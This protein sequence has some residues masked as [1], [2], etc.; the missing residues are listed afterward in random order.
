MKP[1]ND[2]DKKTLLTDR[3]FPIPDRALKHPEQQRIKT[4]LDSHRGQFYVGVI[5]AGRRSFKTERFLK[6]R[7]VAKSI[8][9]PNERNFLGAP[10]RPQAKLI[11]WDDV[12]AL[13]PDYLIKD[14][15]ETELRI[16]YINGTQLYIVGLK[17]YDRVHGVRWNRV[18]ISEYQEC[19][20]KIFSTTLQPL[21]IDTRGEAI[22]EGRPAGK[23]HFYDDFLRAKT[24]PER[25]ASFWWSSEDILDADQ[26]S[27]AKDDLGLVDYKREYLADFESGSQKAYYA[28]SEGNHKPYTLNPELPVIV[29]C[30]FNAGEKPMSWVVG[31]AIGD[32]NYWTHSLAYQFTNTLTMCGILDDTLKTGMKK[33]PPLLRF[34]GDY[35]GVK[36]TSNSSRSDWEII[37]DYFANKTA[38]ETRIKPCHSVRDR[39]AATNARLCN[40][41]NVCRMYANLATCRALIKDWQYVDWKDNNVDLDGSNSERTHSSDAIDY[42]ASYEYPVAGRVSGSQ[43]TR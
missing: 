42:Y 41:N 16:D 10:T 23:N 25:W 29:T 30:D 9:Y 34:Y 31:Q 33:Y 7:F 27:A 5:A 43:Q 20:P 35:S 32:L 2:A 36:D 21:L 18:G 1:L 11:F 19:H 3:W 15:N 12:K 22:V 40:A 24:S 14:I 39:V 6:R 13:S 4:V 28:Y 37:K 38:V 17:E 26:I 8:E